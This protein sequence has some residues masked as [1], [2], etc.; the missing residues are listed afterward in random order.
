MKKPHVVPLAPQVIALLEAMHEHSGG[1]NLVF[2]SPFSATRCIS[3]MGLLNA[4]RRLG[5]PPN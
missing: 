5:Y 1:G 2:P 4:I 3:D